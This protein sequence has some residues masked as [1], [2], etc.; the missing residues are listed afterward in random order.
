M[1][2]RSDSVRV[3]GLSSVLEEM[4]ATR[5]ASA[6]GGAEGAEPAGTRW[7]DPI[8]AARSLWAPV[9]PSLLRERQLLCPAALSDRCRSPT[10]PVTAHP[11]PTSLKSI[12][13]SALLHIH[14]GSS[15][16]TSPAGVL[17]P[18]FGEE[19]LCLC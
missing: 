19:W 7:S 3:S 4:L 13:C 15:H 8:C 1:D 2:Q 14:Q 17:L 16:L 12:I 6:E 10:D 5:D 11:F 18:G 9:P